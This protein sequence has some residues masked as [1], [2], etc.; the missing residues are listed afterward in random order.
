M[1]AQILRSFSSSTI[2]SH[3]QGASITTTTASVDSTMILS[4]TCTNEEP[5]GEVTLAVTCPDKISK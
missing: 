4:V 3:C 2:P 5:E 1:R